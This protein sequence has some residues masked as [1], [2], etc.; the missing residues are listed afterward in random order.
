MAVSCFVAALTVVASVD[1]TMIWL[2]VIWLASRLNWASSDSV[3]EADQDDHRRDPD[4]DPVTRGDE[5][6]VASNAP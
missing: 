4:D 3:A 6:L 2:I 5:D 1:F